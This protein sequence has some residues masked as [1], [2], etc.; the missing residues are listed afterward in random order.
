[1]KSTDNTEYEDFHTFYHA[2]F[3]KL[4]DGLFLKDDGIINYPTLLQIFCVMHQSAP[5]GTTA[6]EVINDHLTEL[7]DPLLNVLF[8]HDHIEMEHES[9]VT[10]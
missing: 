10:D 6:Y 4:S 7:V 5:V 8:G 2:F 3:D 1:M 9:G